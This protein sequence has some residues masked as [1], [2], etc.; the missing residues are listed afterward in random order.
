[1]NTI[2]K[3]GLYFLLSM[4]TIATCMMSAFFGAWLQLGDKIFLAPFF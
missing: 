2:Y 1:M 4:G 3:L